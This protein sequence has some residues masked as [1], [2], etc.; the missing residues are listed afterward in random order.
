MKKVREI[1]E[2]QGQESPQ[3]WYHHNFKYHTDAQKS[4][5]K[6]MAS[7][8]TQTIH[9]QLQRLK[10]WQVNKCQLTISTIIQFTHPRRRNEY[11]IPAIRN[12]WNIRAEALKCLFFA[13]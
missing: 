13:Q 10:S 12:E 11:E 4:P 2:S 5:N 7:K 6:K 9:V 8:Q 3:H 1:R